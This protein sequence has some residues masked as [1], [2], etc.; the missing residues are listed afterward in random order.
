MKCSAKEIIRKPKSE[1]KQNQK[2]ITIKRK[3][4]EKQKKASPQMQPKEKIEQFLS[5]CGLSLRHE[6]PSGTIL[7]CSSTLAKEST[8]KAPQMNV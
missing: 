4:K 1:E 3:A 8:A 2:K 5:K 6:R 7:L